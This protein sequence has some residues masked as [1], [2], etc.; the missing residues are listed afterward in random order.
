MV[1]IL[2]V[3]FLVIPAAKSQNFDPAAISQVSKGLTDTQLLNNT[4]SSTPN[5]ERKENGISTVNRPGLSGFDTDF[6]WV[7]KDNIYA[8]GS[9]VR[10]TGIGLGL[11]IAGNYLGRFG[12]YLGPVYTVGKTSCDMWN[13]S[14][15]KSPEAFYQATRGTPAWHLGVA[16]K[17]LDQWDLTG[18][19]KEADAQY[20]SQQAANWMKITP[21]NIPAQYKELLIG[22]KVDWNKIA[23]P[24]NAADWSKIVKTVNPDYMTK[25]PAI[26]TSIPNIQLGTATTMGT[27]TLPTVNIPKV[28]TPSMPLPPVRRLVD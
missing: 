28:S 7:Q 4:L 15:A 11:D 24:I 6:K 9:T 25:L 26:T 23:P 18:A 8:I 1:F 2:F 19:L 12:P 22:N 14:Q 13:I 10:G 3:Y 20:T 27:T 21:T 17:I 5:V 16:V